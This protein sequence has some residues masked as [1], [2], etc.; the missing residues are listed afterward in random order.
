MPKDFHEWAI[1]PEGVAD[2]VMNWDRVCHHERYDGCKGFGLLKWLRDASLVHNVSER[3]LRVWIVAASQASVH[4]GVIPSTKSVELHHWVVI[5]VLLEVANHRKNAIDHP[6]FLSVEPCRCIRI[7]KILVIES[8][9]S[10]WWL[11]IFRGVVRIS[12]RMGA[13]NICHR[14]ACNAQQVLMRSPIP[15]FEVVVVRT[16]KND[17]TGEVNYVVKHVSRRR[18]VTSK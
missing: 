5:T 10:N 3:P 7:Y 2:L 6:V 18:I 14:V 15:D 12:M 4:F 8:I 11:T 16:Y 17:P 13:P 9:N 1:D